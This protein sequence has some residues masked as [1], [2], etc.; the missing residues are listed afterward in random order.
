MT[1]TESE[2]SIPASPT[3]PQPATHPPVHWATRLHRRIL[4]FMVLL[5]GISTALSLISVAAYYLVIHL[6]QAQAPQVQTV[7]PAGRVLSV[8]LI[9]GLL[10]RGWVETDSGYYA[11]EQGISLTKSSALSLE[12]RNTGAFLCDE[13]HRCT[14][15]LD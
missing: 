3:T 14:R 15:L 10:S 9:G 11:L 8:R 2:P 6:A 1:T 13:Q 4:M 7:R 12:Q 5:L